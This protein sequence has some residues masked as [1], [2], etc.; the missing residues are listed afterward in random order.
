MINLKIDDFVIRFNNR[1]ILNGLSQVVGFDEARSMDVFR[2]LDKL[3]KIGL[4]EVIRELQRPP[5]NEYDESAVAISDAGIDRLKEFLELSGEL[6]E[7][8]SFFRGVTLAQEGI[9]ECAQIIANLRALAIPERYWKLDLSIARGLGYYTGPV[10]ETTLLDI[11]EIGSVF[12]GGRY[13]ELVIRYTGERVPA[14]GA[15]IGVDR[16]ISALDTLGRIEKKRTNSRVLVAFA[17]ENLGR[18][19]LTLARR[20]RQSGINTETFMG[21]DTALKNQIIYA[22]KQGIPF[23]V[24]LGEEEEAM[25]KVKFK[26][27]ALRQE[28]LCSL[29]EVIEKF[30]RS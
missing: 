6:D 15:S 27:M 16:L 17:S 13:D 20:I 2:I 14:T 24:I 23:V 4:E 11:P 29:E 18:K 22:V 9:N 12:S 25:G 3:D 26:D 10:F 28:S 1:K 7:L 5:D 19:A 21:K 30:L 8:M